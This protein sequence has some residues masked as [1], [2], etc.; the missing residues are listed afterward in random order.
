[1]SASTKF[2]RVCRA[3][4]GTVILLAVLFG[5]SGCK[6][7]PAK[8]PNDRIAEK[9]SES[10]DTTGLTLTATEKGLEGTGKREDGESVD[11]IVT[12]HPESSEIRWNAQGDRGFIE[13]GK[14]QLR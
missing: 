13:E 11:V 12:L 3:E 6:E 14:F 9:V 10:L 1:M 7:N 8:W 5:L 2:G 4:M